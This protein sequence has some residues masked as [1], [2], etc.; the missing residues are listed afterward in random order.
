MRSSLNLNECFDVEILG[1]AAAVFIGLTL[2]LLG[3][4]GSILSIP[5]LI[6]FFDVE[7]VRATAYS[8]FIVGTTSLVGVVPK[9]REG[10][11]NF[12]SAIQ[13]GIPSVI[14]IFATRKWFLPVLPDTLFTWG[15]VVLSRRLF[16]LG[17][18]SF[19]MIAAAWHL[20]R[21]ESKQPSPPKQGAS[22]RMTLQGAGVGFLTGLVGAGGGFLIT[23]ALVYLTGLSFKMAAGTSLL[24][25]AV[26]SLM[27]FVGDVM[28]FSMEWTFLL[29]LTSLAILGIFIGSKLATRYSSQTLKLFFGWFV[30]AIALYILA[31]EIT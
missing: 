30:L 9:Y 27:G 2:G 6:Y 11:I 13:F 28:N 17:L 24:I 31:R 18:F 7:P 29:P 5:V 22:Y 20:L 26:N 12:R 21:K 15:T 4:G 10:L 16:L 1:Y 25:I 8:L 14:S 19:L 23:P 3:G